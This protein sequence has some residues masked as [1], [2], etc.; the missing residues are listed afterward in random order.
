MK[1]AYLLMHLAI[2]LWG[3]TGILGKAIQMNESL[4]VWYRLLITSVSLLPLVYYR[5]EFINISKK[6]LLRIF[7]VGF[8]I[9]LH[10]ILFYLAIKISNVSITLSCF[11]TI[12]LF[13]AL[14]EPMYQ[15][16]WPKLLE[17]FL[18]LVVLCGLFCIYQVQQ[19]SLA[20]ILAAVGAAFL[21]SMFT[22]E[23]KY[24]IKEIKPSFL[25]WLEITTG[26]VILSMV[27]P[28]YLS[29]NQISFSIPEG[30]DIMYLLLLSIICTTIAFT[31][32]L[33]A[34]ETVSAF[35]MNLSVNL[36]PIYSIVLAIIIFKEGKEL[37]PGFY[38]GTGIILL[39]VLLYSY[40][41]FRKFRKIK[42]RGATASVAPP[43]I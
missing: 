42:K 28:F 32:S 6:T 36:E 26:F 16:K 27:L 7:F 18:S 15:K 5:K 22:V 38:L 33:I 30:W 37:Q 3:F 40:L 41:Q 20:G 43:V 29:F 39:A 35:T 19:S 4:I 25:T 12:T 2:L 31:I 24:L 13:T 9:A 23:N 14:L 1:R 34:L 21:G 10:W 8:L 11:A 17:L